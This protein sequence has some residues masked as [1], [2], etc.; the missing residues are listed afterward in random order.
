MFVIAI[1]ILAGL[2]AAVIAAIVLVLKNS[3]WGRRQVARVGGAPGCV[4]IL[5][6][7][8]VLLIASPA[9]IAA[10][11]PASS[12]YAE[13]FG[14]EPGPAITNLKGSSG[15]GFDYRRAF[16]AFDRTDAALAEILA[17]G[18]VTPAD[19]ASARVGMAVDDG[20]EWWKTAWTCPNRVQRIVG[21]QA[22]WDEVT[23]VECPTERRVYVLASNID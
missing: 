13:V 21:G 2:A 20:P 8:V 9:I 6:G 3:A 22:D 12:D 4:A 7:L 16:L 5:V 11:Q 17:R 10:V 1:G 19:P 23:V 18:P 15:G 14:V